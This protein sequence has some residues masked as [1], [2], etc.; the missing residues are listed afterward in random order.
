[1]KILVLLT[2]LTLLITA[3]NNTPQA[4]QEPQQDNVHAK[5]QVTAQG[6]DIQDTDTQDIDAQGVVIDELP[7]ASL[8]V[9]ADRRMQIDWSQIDT[10]VAPINPNEYPYPFAVDSIPV[11]NYANAYNISPSQA[12]HAMTLAMAAP[13]ALNK[14]LDQLTNGTYLGHELTD[15]A[16]MTLIIHT[17]ADVVGETHEYVFADK[18]GEGLVLPI[19]IRPTQQ[20]Q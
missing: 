9:L 10:A 20:S 17:S 19:E 14:I 3:C 15:G 11:Q 18:F 4:A 8:M 6:I 16:N 7:N 5:A 2:V 13:E 1:M 12:Q